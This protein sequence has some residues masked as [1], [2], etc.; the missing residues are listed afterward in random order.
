MDLK[1]VTKNDIKEWWQ[2]VKPAGSFFDH[3]VNF[4]RDHGYLK[5]KVRKWKWVIKI[6]GECKVTSGYYAS[7]S[8]MSRN[9]VKG[10]CIQRIDLEWI[11][12]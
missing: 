6:N 4:A 5:E 3:I 8:E 1:Q 10:Q 7:M 11:E 9:K 2:E 12:E